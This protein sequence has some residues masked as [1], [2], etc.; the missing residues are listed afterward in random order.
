MSLWYDSTR[1]WTQFFRA[2]GIMVSVRQCSVQTIMLCN[3]LT[4]LSWTT[5]KY[6]YQWLNVN[7][8]FNKTNNWSFFLWTFEKVKSLRL[9]TSYLNMDLLILL[10]LA[11]DSLSMRAYFSLWGIHITKKFKKKQRKTIFV[12]VLLMLP[13]T[14]QMIH[15][16]AINKCI[17]R[18]KKRLFF[19]IT[20]WI[21]HQKRKEY[22]EKV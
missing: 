21:K 2:I 14:F 16:S 20:F 19:I 1:D 4:L 5:N 13:I 6:N 8:Y 17:L 3:Y 7:D 18:E 22:E 10:F 12:Y 9:V 15:S 11:R